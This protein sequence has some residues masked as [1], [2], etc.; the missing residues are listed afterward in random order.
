LSS[1]IRSIV[2]NQKDIHCPPDA[3][4][5]SDLSY[6]DLDYDTLT[7]ALTLTGLSPSV[8]ENG[9]SASR[10]A[11][12]RVEVGMLNN[13]KPDEPE[14]LKLGGFLTIIGEDTSPSATLFS[15]PSRHHALPASH[16]TTYKTTFQHPTGLHPVL[17]L[18]L[19]SDNENA[20]TPPAANCALHAYLTLPSSLFVDKYQFS[21]ALFLGSNNLRSLRALS[22]ETDLE[23]PDW[24]MDK[25]GSAALFELALPGETAHSASPG[26]W[27]VSIPLHLRY[28]APNSTTTT[29]NSEKGESQRP[30]TTSETEIQIPHPVLFYAC[31]AEEGLK[32][33]TNPFDRVNLGYEGLFGPKT[34]FYHVPSR[35]RE[36]VAEIEVPVLS[37]TEEGARW[38]EYGTGV[39]VLLGFGWV[40]WALFGPVKASAGKEMAKGKKKE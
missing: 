35:D 33:S 10:S 40:L 16:R 6:L 34:L 26:E 20:L 36:L 37:V 31:P 4:D 39:A 9:I 29:T 21:D 13:E 18:D 23:A 24:V 11:P 15:F 14:E 2:C 12:D 22:G 17:Q 19:R 30:G 7:H 32:M 3:F 1:Y 25:W 28:L 38:V 8:G 27:D 5:L